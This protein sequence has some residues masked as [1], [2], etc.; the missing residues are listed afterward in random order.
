MATYSM[1]A[2]AGSERVAGELSISGKTI[3]GETPFVKVN[4]EA[5]QSGRSIFSSSTIATP[6]N[7][8]AIISLGKIGRIE[9][10]P[11][12]TLNLAFDENGISGDLL[13]G[14]VTVLNSSDTV[15]IKTL[16][17]TIAKL[18]AGNSAVA[19]TGK[20]K[21]DDSNGG[22][23]H[24]AILWAIILG[25]AAVGIIIAATTNNNDVTLGGGVTV[26]SPTR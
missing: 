17:G 8:S 9:L 6:E 12:T 13:A 20:T 15:N 5:A 24:G 25:G 14:Q 3:N 23:G 7:A 10:A 26:I 11:N 1:V 2:L 22:G 16:D 21:D 18:N 4:G 19:T